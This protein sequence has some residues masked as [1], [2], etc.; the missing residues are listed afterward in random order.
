MTIISIALI[1]THIAFMLLNRKDMPIA[2]RS[3]PIYATHPHTKLILSLFLLFLLKQ[4]RCSQLSTFSFCLF[5]R[6]DDRVED[7]TL[8]R[9][10]LISPCAGSFRRAARRESSCYLFNAPRNVQTHKRFVG[11]E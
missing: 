11:E 10:D 5:F 9:H 6:W 2:L 1:P 8:N 7:E 4:R 3:S